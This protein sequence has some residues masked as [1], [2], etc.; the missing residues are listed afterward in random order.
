[1]HLSRGRDRLAMLLIVALATCLPARDSAA[2]AKKEKKPPRTNPAHR[3]SRDAPQGLGNTLTPAVFLIRDPVVLDELNLSEWQSAGLAELAH[4]ANEEAW[5]FRDVAPDAAA[6]SAAIQK[7][8]DQMDA[9]LAKLLTVRQIERMEQI[10]LQVQ[11][12]PAVQSPKIVERLGLSASQRRSI[13]GLI[14]ENQRSIREVREKARAGKDPA[15]LSR[16]IGELQ[17]GLNNDLLAML[18]PSQRKKWTALIGKPLDPARLQPL[19]ARAPELR[20]IE[21]W[22]NSEPL[23]IAGLRGNVVALHFWTFG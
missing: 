3:E 14:T 4:A 8:N 21:A 13:A 2:Q 23:T 18:D 9:R 6:A 20:G 5:K 22:I 19:L 15:A 10:I 12:P 11:G 7:L 1:M 17:S 16:Q